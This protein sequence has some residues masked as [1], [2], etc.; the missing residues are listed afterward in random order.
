MR[1]DKGK[2]ST[3]DGGRTIDWGRTSSDYAEHRPG[4]PPSYYERLGWF[5]IGTPEQRVLDLATGTGSIARS[6]AAQGCNV[7]GIDIA[8]SQ[9]QMAAE[10]AKQ[11]GVEIDFRFG[12]VEELPWDDNS[13]EVA[14]ANQCWLYFQSERVIPELRRVL[15]PDGRIAIS[16]FSFMPRECE[17]AAASEELVMTHNPDWGG[18]DWNGHLPMDPRWAGRGLRR[19]DVVI[20]DEAIRFTRESWRGRM[21]ALRGIGASLPDEQVETFDSEHAALLEKIAPAEFD[22]VHRL[23]IHVFAFDDATTGA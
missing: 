17:I 5:G 2:T 14:T 22:I 10:L 15:G 7:A 21:R 16:H 11:D 20:W 6:L 23:D 12:P 8:E 3:I 18:G 13:F 9:T 1:P 4:P 19:S